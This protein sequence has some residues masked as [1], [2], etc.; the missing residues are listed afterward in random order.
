MLNYPYT[1]N[2]IREIVSGGKALRRPELLVKGKP[3]PFQ[4]HGTR[5]R[6]IDLDL[7]LTK[8]STLLDLRFHVRASIVDSPETF[9]AALI[10]AHQRVRGIGWHATGKKRF[11]GRQIIP[12]GWH[13]NVID[14]NL[15]PNGTDRNRHV[16]IKDFEPSD[17]AAFFME[18]AKLWHINLPIEETL[19]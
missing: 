17:L 1:T 19:L 2:Q 12:K 6:K 11:Y 9:E 4:S 18:A 3:L 5:G 15:E 8:G 16:P 10:L 7:E 14:P 13:Q